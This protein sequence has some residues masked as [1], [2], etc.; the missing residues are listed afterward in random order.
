MIQ[1][2]VKLRHEDHRYFH[3]DGRELKSVSH[4]LNT[5][6]EKVDWPSVAKKVAGRGKFAGMTSEEVLKLWD[7]KKVKGTTHGSRYHN[8][9]EGYGKT[10][11]VD[12]IELEPLVKSIY[13]TYTDYYQTMDEVCL[14]S[15]T[16]GVAG[17][18]DKL[19]FKK[20]NNRTV[21]IEDYKT[22]LTGLSFSNKDGKYLKGPVSH[23]QDCT[24][25]KHCLQL[26]LYALMYQE[27][28]GGDIEEMWVRYIPPENPMAHY[29][30]PIPYLKREAIA[31]MEYFKHQSGDTY[32][33]VTEAEFELPN[34]D[35]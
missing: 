7:D 11:T 25:S 30:I 18:T 6:S 1:N 33:Q 31:V 3:L 28:T 4:V 20:K 8:A 34:F 26:S 21:S 2:L 9:L 13:Q 23:L 24:Y 17:T 29:K 15:D 32:V 14:F 16:F 10:F 35:I 5:L 19:L 12:D 27:L 22:N